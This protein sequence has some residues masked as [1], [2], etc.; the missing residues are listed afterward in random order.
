M[1]LAT[2]QCPPVSWDSPGPHLPW[3]PPV[4]NAPYRWLP[5]QA[6]LRLC[7]L[8]PSYPIPPTPTRPRAHSLSTYLQYIPRQSTRT[9]SVP[10]YC[11]LHT[12]HL[13]IYIQSSLHTFRTASPPRNFNRKG[14]PVLPGHAVVRPSHLGGMLCTVGTIRARIHARA[15]ILERTYASLRTG[16]G[17]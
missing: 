12:Y 3:S 6:A 1:S 15:L 17:R 5:L 16:I 9:H 11:Q 14:S 13:P 7:A 10:S 8:L 2:R 4:Y